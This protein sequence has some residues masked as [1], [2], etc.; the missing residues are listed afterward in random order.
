[1][2][3]G[4]H[5]V[6]GFGLAGLSL[7]DPIV[8]KDSTIMTAVF[9][10]T[11][12]GSQAPDSDTLLRCKD[13]AAYIRNHRG[14]THSL[15]FLAIWTLLI[16]GVLALV[17]RGLPLFHVGMWVFIAVAFHVFTDCFNTYGTQAFRPFTHKWI[18]WNIIHIFDPFIFASHVLCIL[19]WSFHLVPPEIVFPV[20]YGII[21]LYYVWRTVVHSR[22]EKGLSR[23]D[24]DYQNG[25]QYLLIPTY[26]LYAWNI[27]KTRADG[28]YVLGDLRNNRLRWVDVVICDNHPAVEASKTNT[29]IEALLH[30]SSY[31]CAAVSQHPWGYEVRWTDVRYRHRKQYPFVAV[32]LMDHDYRHLNS[33]VGWLSETKLEK[34]LNLNSH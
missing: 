26:S 31:T 15:P 32:L 25:D 14:I 21:A 13:N 3:T 34:R 7:I 11:V 8:A 4:T 27:V 12:L 10:G 17:F 18:S 24:P 1:M 19:L 5:L 30:F 20:L 6:I 28:T 23:Q 9:I 16:T 22:L 2:D 33:Y 29:D